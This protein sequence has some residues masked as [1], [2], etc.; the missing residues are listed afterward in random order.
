MAPVWVAPKLTTP[1]SSTNSTRGSS[2]SLSGLL[3]R[4]AHGKTFDGAL[5]GMT[6][7]AIAAEITRE[8]KSFALDIGDIVFEYHDVLIGNSFIRARATEF[9]RI[10]VRVLAVNRGE[11]HH[12]YGYGYESKQ[13]KRFLHMTSSELRTVAGL[14]WERPLLGKFIDTSGTNRGLGSFDDLV[15]SV[16]TYLG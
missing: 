1:S 14:N 9:R 12:C 4:H 8:A 2:A 3:F 7:I 10:A 16:K 15:G 6:A 11:D 13:H 5:V